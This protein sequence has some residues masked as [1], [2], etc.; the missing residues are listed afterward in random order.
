MRIP[1]T[2][3]SIIVLFIPAVS[4]CQNLGLTS[5]REIPIIKRGKTYEINWVGGVSDESIIIQL[6]NKDGVIKELNAVANTG[7]YSIQIPTR[8][9]L[10]K[11]SLKLVSAKS[12]E[13]S[14]SKEFSVRRRIPLIVQ[15]SPLIV[16]PAIILIM[17]PKDEVDF[18][19]P[20]LP[21]NN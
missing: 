10:G 13:V 6:V 2:I 3:A 15:L 1:I 4:F 14:A 8:T 7:Q 5:I 9:R 19:A 11:Y 18:V 17:R 20:P 21:A 16:I 12:G